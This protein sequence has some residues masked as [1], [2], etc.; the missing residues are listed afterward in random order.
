VLRDG[1][2]GPNEQFPVPGDPRNLRLR[3]LAQEQEMA[4][5]RGWDSS[6]IREGAAPGDTGGRC[7]EDTDGG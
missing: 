7:G 6:G 1:G 2:G 5:V 3:R 4:A